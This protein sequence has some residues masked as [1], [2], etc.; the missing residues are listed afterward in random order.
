MLLA[1]EDLGLLQMLSQWPPATAN[2]MDLAHS[3]ARV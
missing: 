2:I 1:A 3:A